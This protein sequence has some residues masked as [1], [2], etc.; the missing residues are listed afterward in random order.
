MLEEG[1][2]HTGT[3][4]G[5]P[6]PWVTKK[7]NK[8]CINKKNLPALTPDP[9]NRGLEPIPMC[10]MPLWALLTPRCSAVVLW[11]E[12][13]PLLLGTLCSML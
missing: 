13:S 1:C 6:F 9:I 12:I 3:T 11:E 5:V 7:I 4:A 2:T 10:V 8:I